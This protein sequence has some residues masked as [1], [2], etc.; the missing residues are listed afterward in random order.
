MEIFDQ[1][2]VYLDAFLVAPYRYFTIPIVGFYVGTLLLCLWCIVIGE[3]T[4][5]IANWANKAHMN[6][7]RGQ[8]VKMHNLSIKA[9]ALKD[10]ENYRSCNT[11]ANEAFGK[12][13]FNMITQGAAFLWPV[14]FALAWMGTR[15]SGVEFELP[16]AL[17]ITGDT[18][19]YAAVPVNMYILCRILWGEIRPYVP[20]F[21][22]IP[23]VGLNEGA[24]EM[25]SWGDLGKTGKLP[26]RFWYSDESPEESKADPPGNA[27]AGQKHHS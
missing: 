19:S 9:I 21:K 17:P 18:L 26:D 10:K 14:P 15:F 16:F 4:Y 1:L 23:R 3:L 20:F 13:F 24:E 2:Y 7:L 5:R 12:Y 6:K 22:Q 8:A 11:E 27:V 25:I